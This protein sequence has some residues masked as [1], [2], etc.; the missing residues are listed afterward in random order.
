MKRITDLPEDSRYS[1]KDW[2]ARVS[3]TYNDRGLN[4][5][6][7]FRLSRQDQ[8]KNGG[9]AYAQVNVN[10]FGYDD[11]VLRGNGILRIPPNFN[12]F[13]ER[14]RPRKGDWEF[15]GNFGISNYGIGD[16]RNE[17]HVGW[18]TQFQPTY[19]ISDAF[20][21]YTTLFAERTPQWVL[22]QGGN[23]VGS[24]D[25]HAQQLD[26]GVNWNIGNQHEIR[27]KMQALGLD[28]KLRQL[29]QAYF[30]AQDGTPVPTDEPVDDFSLSN[31]GFQMRYRWEFKPLSYLYVVYGRGGDLFNEF[32]LDSREALR[33]SF[34]L[35]D[36]EQLVVKLSYRFEL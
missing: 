12:A 36:S 20:S 32:S 28:A 34:D 5:S 18:N 27:V 7:Q 25:E 22:W 2:R 11:R 9:S 14:S 24:F 30:V 31:L 15:Y 16:D 6:E 29:R 4:L 26:F 23:L 13:I 3:A 8:L 19:Y 1:S 33:D 21:L 17:R 10:S 35:R